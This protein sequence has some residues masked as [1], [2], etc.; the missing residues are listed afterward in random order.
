MGGQSKERSERQAKRRA[1]LFILIKFLLVG[2][3]NTL[4]DWAVY[5]ILTGLL[6]VETFVAQPLGYIAGAVNSYAINRKLTFKS[7]KR[8]FSA[9]LIKFA[10]VIAL[11]ATASALLMG[12]VTEGW[13]VSGTPLLD[14]AAK[15]GVTAFTMLFNFA[16]NRLWVFRKGK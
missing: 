2:V 10:A 9:Q 12:L 15:I 11:T 3:G 13:G 5:F 4:I 16:L 14:I 6:S 1:E 8:F 7:E